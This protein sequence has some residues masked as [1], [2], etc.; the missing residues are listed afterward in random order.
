MPNQLRQQIRLFDRLM[1]RDD[2]GN[3]SGLRQPSLQFL[4]DDRPIDIHVAASVAPPRLDQSL[5]IVDMMIAVSPFVAHP[6][7]V[8]ERILPRAEPI[9]G[10]LIL[11]HQD[12]AAG[13][14]AGAHVRM[15]LH[16][17]DP[18][19]VEEIL[20]AERPDRAEID[21]VAR[22]LVGQ[23]MAGEDVDL[24]VAAAI[25]HQQLLRAADLA[26]EPHA[27]AAHH[28]AIDKERDRFAQL[29]AAAGEGAN[30]GPPLALAVLEV[31]VLQQTFARFVADRA[32]D[33]MVDQQV[34]LDLRAALL[35]RF[36]VGDE[37][38]PRLGRRLTSGHKLGN[39]RDRAGLGMLAPGLDEAHPA[40]C[41]DRQPRMP[42]IVRNLDAGPL[43]R[44]NP[45]QAL[46]VA[47]FD[48]LAVDQDDA[49][50]LPLQKN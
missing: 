27:A 34:F 13:R 22:H 1:R 8:D 10:V 38:G 45:V 47:D 49:H 24:F 43:R 4:R 2:R 9:D 6:P 21:H 46:I 44:L 37:H 23:R 40:A 32:I 11:V 30:V 15:A 5:R 19:L 17:P 14:A 31:I 16:E 48:F 26:G 50:C 20:V 41:D 29:A 12:R 36:A 35:D 42:A 3:P 7:F 28:A 33:R 18:L 25:G 39:H